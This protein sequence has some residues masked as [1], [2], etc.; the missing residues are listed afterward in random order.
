MAYAASRLTLEEARPLRAP[1]VTNHPHYVSMI[2]PFEGFTRKSRDNLTR[3]E[4]NQFRTQCVDSFQLAIP[5]PKIINYKNVDQEQEGACTFVSLLNLAAL[6]GSNGMF[7]VKSWKKAWRSFDT[8]MC[9]DLADAL[10]LCAAHSL[11]SDSAPASLVYTPIRSRG[12]REMCFNTSFWTADLAALAATY[13][14]R[15]EDV[16]ATPWVYQNARFVEHLLDEGTPVAINFAEHSRTCVGYNESSLLFCDNWAET[17]EEVCD[18]G[19]TYESVFRAGLSVLE[20]RIT[21]FV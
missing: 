2:F 11:L 17:Y 3:A 20:M 1:R 9:E 8:P 12:K 13:G 14:V 6:T 15:V 16:E 19:G 4:I 21:Q 10:D 18:T 7:R 5:G